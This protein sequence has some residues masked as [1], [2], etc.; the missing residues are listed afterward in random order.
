MSV[1]DEAEMINR[2]QQRSV[3]TLSKIA[4]ERE[5]LVMIENNMKKYEQN[6]PICSATR[7][8][9]NEANCRLLCGFTSQDFQT[10]YDT[11]RF[12][13]LRKIGRG[14]D[15][16]FNSKDRLRHYENWSKLAIETKMSTR[17]DVSNWSN[18]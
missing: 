4:I 3:Q 13:I 18:L 11:V 5:H 10:I 8:L 2:L 14:K 9:S 15:Y 17:M 7:Q 12:D 6:A 1:T 16:K